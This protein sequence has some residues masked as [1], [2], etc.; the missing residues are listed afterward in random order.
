ML[1]TNHY[2]KFE[3][4]HIDSSKLTPTKVE[5]IQ[6]FVNL[7]KDAKFMGVEVVNMIGAESMFVKYHGHIKVINQIEIYNYAKDIVNN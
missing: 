5:L 4:D 2:G 7:E 1:K 6:E 3:V